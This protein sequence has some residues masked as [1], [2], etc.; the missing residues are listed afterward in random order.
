MDTKLHLHKGPVSVALRE[1]DTW[2]LA[3]ARRWPEDLDLQQ[4]TADIIKTCTDRRLPCQYLGTMPLFAGHRVHQ[5]AERD[6]ALMPLAEDPLYQDRHGYPMPTQV[7]ETLGSI[8]DTGVTFDVI[9]VAHEVER[10]AIVEGQLID[11]RTVMPP[12]APSAQRRS[13]QLGSLAATL[14]KVAAAPLLAWGAASLAVGA[15]TAATAAAASA[16]GA[17]A[18]LDPVILGVVVRPGSQP[19]PGEPG[20]W[21][22]LA[23]WRYG[24]EER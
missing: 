6:W 21:F 15:A 20:C 22:Y 14:F 17:M 4:R 23:H 9:Y 10:D 3:M 12:P 11:P 19:Q 1:E 7:M 24:E 2:Q 16:V 5:G 18:L 13:K 8:L